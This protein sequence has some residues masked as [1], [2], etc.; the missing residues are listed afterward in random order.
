M[1]VL[2][3]SDV[4]WIYWTAAAWGSAINLGKDRP[5]LTADIEVVKALIARGLELDETYD[6]GA[7]HEAMIL[8]ESLPK[9][10]G[11]SPERAHQHLIRAIDLS[12]GERISPYVTYA[13][14]VSV[15]AQNRREFRQLLEKAL[16]LDPDQHPKRRLETLLIQRKARTLLARQ[17][18]L[19][20]DS[21]TTSVEESR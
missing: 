10:M 16:E 2:R 13:Q 11:G 6:Q 1:K 15:A 18:E 7:L 14:S 12:H 3:K 5:D 19:F 4:P 20:L 17:D 21:D 9:A 8:M